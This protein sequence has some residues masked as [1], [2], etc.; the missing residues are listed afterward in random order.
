M[1]V[2][3]RVRLRLRVRV[4]VVTCVWRAV[5]YCTVQCSV[6]QY[7]YNQSLYVALACAGVSCAVQYVF[8]QSIKSVNRFPTGLGPMVA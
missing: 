7:K 1:R 3:V 2:R 5:R 6:M 4:T 8:I